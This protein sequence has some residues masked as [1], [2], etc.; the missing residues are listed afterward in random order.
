MNKSLIRHAIQECIN[1]SERLLS[2]IRTLECS[3]SPSTA[4]ALV[5]IVQE[6]LAKA[7]LLTLVCKGVITWNDFIWRATRDHVCKQLISMVMDY[8]NPGVDEFIARLNE[9]LEERLKGTLPCHI[10]DAINIFRHEKIGRWQS[11]NWWWADPPNYDQKAKKVS[12]GE[13]DRLKQSQLYVNIGKNGSAIPRTSVTQT[14]L[15]DE[16]DRAERLLTLV[17]RMIKEDD[18]LYLGYKE[19]TEA[20]QVLFANM[21][22][23]GKKDE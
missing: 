18:P 7:F 12:N 9:P 19:V 4:F 3:E 21:I 6:E 13:V 20:F 16:K 15:D 2:D 5:I 14:Q 11:H 22:L 17:S 8:L 23:D 1:T 10:A